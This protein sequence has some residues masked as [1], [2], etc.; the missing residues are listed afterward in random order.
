MT[1]DKFKPFVPKTYQQFVLEE[2]QTQLTG[3]DL[4]IADSYANEVSAYGNLEVWEGYGPCYVCIKPQQWKDLYLPC[5]GIKDGNP[6]DNPRKTSW[7]HASDGGEAE[8]SNRAHIR[9]KRCYSDTHMSY[10]AFRCERHEGY[11]GTTTTT[12]RKS[13][14]SVMGLECYDDF[15]DDV[16]AYM[17]SH[18]YDS[19][20]RSGW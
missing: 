7:R 5:P 15:V 8:I 13:L 20:V 1:N 19:D 3:Q 6:C 4:K 10:C 16:I 11:W 9:C 12:F 18:R 17:S 14:N 2:Q